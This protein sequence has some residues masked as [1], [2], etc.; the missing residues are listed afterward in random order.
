MGSRSCA[1]CMVNY[2]PTRDMEVY[3]RLKSR[4]QA[5]MALAD[6]AASGD[7]DPFTEDDAKLELDYRDRQL[8][9]LRDEIL[10]LD[11]PDDTP[12][13]SDFTLDYFFA[14]L[15]RYL[16]KNRS[17]LEAIPLGA[18][19]V[20]RPVDG[21]AGPGVIFFLRQLNANTAPKP[22]QRIASPIH[23]FYAVHI[24][25]D[26]YI[27]FGCANARQVLEAFEAATAGKT[28]AILSLCDRFN[29][30]TDNGRNMKRYDALLNAVLAHIAQVN[31]S[32]QAGGLGLG[33]SR[34]FTL[35]TAAE[36]P[37]AADFELVTWLVI[38]SAGKVGES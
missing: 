8:L 34:D 38:I 9:K 12:A 6:M 36:S 16:E 27:R 19:A 2:W 7:E 26:G 30:E 28:D 3:L 20:T 18:C 35:P 33:G 25:Y 21:P 1:V 5:R 17:E 37:A 10:D 31:R 4:A 32:V 11:G 22:R 29:A 15:L 13:M 24:G 23:P 14:Q